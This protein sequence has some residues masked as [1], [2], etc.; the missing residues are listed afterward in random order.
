MSDP[1]RGARCGR[2]DVDGRD[3]R[4]D[5]QQAVLLRF[6]HK[7]PKAVARIGFSRQPRSDVTL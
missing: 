2:P 1:F 5:T 3:D 7:G 4:V 6:S